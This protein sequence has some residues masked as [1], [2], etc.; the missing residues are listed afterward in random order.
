MGAEEH[1]ELKNLVD[2]QKAFVDTV[3]KHTK[4]GQWPN[5][6]NENVLKAF[7]EEA[8]KL[9]ASK[10]DEIKDEFKKVKEEVKEGEN[11]AAKGENTKAPEGPSGNKSVAAASA[12]AA[13]LFFL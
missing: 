2:N 9:N 1:E 8:A 3:K 7:K 12:L 5:L 10:V 6:K 11:K 13:V 4:D